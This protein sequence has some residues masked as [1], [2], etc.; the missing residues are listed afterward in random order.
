M[1]ERWRLWVIAL[2]M[3]CVGPSHDS[4]EGLVCPG[5]DER[6]Q[7]TGANVSDPDECA[8]GTCALFCTS[9]VCDVSTRSKDYFCEECDALEAYAESECAGCARTERN[10][11][12]WLVCT[13]V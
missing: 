8:T 6:Y 7:P 2:S 13:E 1:S 11:A 10:G 4:D 3:A 12:L 9:D 5:T